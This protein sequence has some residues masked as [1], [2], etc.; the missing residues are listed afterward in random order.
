MMSRADVCPAQC[1]WHSTT[2]V[3]IG[4]AKSSSGATYIVGRYT[5]PGNV[6]GQKPY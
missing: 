6:V 1:L 2:D 5:P 3:G 4:K